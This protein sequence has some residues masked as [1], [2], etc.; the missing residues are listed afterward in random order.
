[1]TWSDFTWSDLCSVK[2]LIGAIFPICYPVYEH[3]NKI[4]KEKKKIE[5]LN[6]ETNICVVFVLVLT[7]FFSSSDQAYIIWLKQAAVLWTDPDSF[8]NET[9]WLKKKKKS[10]YT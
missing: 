6:M 5:F 2:A 7:S 8:G 9:N 4:W 3:E 1:M 10:G